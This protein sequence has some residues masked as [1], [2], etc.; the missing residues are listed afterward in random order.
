MVVICAFR[1]EVCPANRAA[2][3]TLHVLADGQLRSAGPAEYCFLV[4][5]T[6]GPHLDL[7]IGERS[8]A[9]LARIVDT[10]ALHLDGNDVSRTPIVFA[11]GIRIKV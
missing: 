4:P 7:M 1:I 8:M 6:L 2:R 10:T 11:T 9:I 5:V 3:F